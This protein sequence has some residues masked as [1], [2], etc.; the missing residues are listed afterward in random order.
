MLRI[1]LKHN[2]RPVC[3]VRCFKTFE[4]GYDYIRTGLWIIQPVLN[5]GTRLRHFQYP[6][7]ILKPELGTRCQPRW[8]AQQSYCSQPDARRSSSVRLLSIFCP[9]VNPSSQ[10]PSS[11]LRLNFGKTTCPL[12]LQMLIFVFQNSKFIIYWFFMIL[13][14]FWFTWD[15]MGVKIS[16]ASPLKLFTPPPPHPPKNHAYS[17]TL[18]LPK[19]LKELWNFQSWI[20]GSFVPFRPL[21]MGNYKMGDILKVRYLRLVIRWISAFCQFKSGKWLVIEYVWQL[22]V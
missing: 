20:F 18:S 3:S 17:Y 14:S 15:H 12:H 22:S 21:N 5:I 19:L 8:A 10:K 9:S 16:T 4:P 2:A 11:E 6:A 7:Q 1:P 13:C